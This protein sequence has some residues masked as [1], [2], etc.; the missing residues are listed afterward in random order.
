MKQT[1]SMLLVVPAV[2]LLAAHVCTAA[3][4]ESVDSARASVAIQKIES[5][6]NQDAVSERLSKMGM[7]RAMVTARLTKLSDAQL[8]EMAAQVDLVQAGGT[9][10]GDSIDE[11]NPVRCV[12]EPLGRLFYNLYQL[13]FCW[14]EFK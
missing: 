14:G 10:Q 7:D 5:F 1:R 12:L 4:V 6:L 13:V 3:P 11:F 8:Q 9:I 2:L